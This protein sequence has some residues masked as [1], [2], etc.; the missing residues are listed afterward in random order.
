MVLPMESNN[1]GVSK[2]PFKSVAIDFATFRIVSFIESQG[3]LSSASFN[4]AP[5]IVPI[6]VKS[7]FFHASFII[8]ASLLNS[9]SSDASSNILLTPEPELDPPPLPESLLLFNIST[10]SNPASVFCNSCA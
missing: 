2:N 6:S 10:S 7:A 1:P 3:I 8:S 5:I 4:L 9:L